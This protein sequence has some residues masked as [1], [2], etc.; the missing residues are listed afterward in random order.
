MVTNL[1]TMKA[2]TFGGWVASSFRR[3]CSKWSYWTSMI[4]FLISGLKK[5]FKE[6]L[7]IRFLREKLRGHFVTLQKSLFFCSI[8]HPTQVM[9]G[10]GGRKLIRV[11]D[12]TSDI[13]Y[14]HSWRRCGGHGRSEK[15]RRFGVLNWKENWWIKGSLFQSA[16]SLMRLRY[17]HA[18]KPILWKAWVLTRLE[19][20]EFCPELME[21][22]SRIPPNQWV[23]VDLH[24]RFLETSTPCSYLSRLDVPN[25]DGS[26][27]YC[28][29]LNGWNQ[30][31]V[32]DQ[33][34]F[35]WRGNQ[36]CCWIWTTYYRHNTKKSRKKAAGFQNLAVRSG[37]T[38]LVQIPWF[39]WQ[40]HLWRPGFLQCQDVPGRDGKMLLVLLARR[41]AGRWC[42]GCF[43]F[44]R[45]KV[46]KLAVGETM[47][48]LLS[49]FIWGK[50]RYL[51]SVCVSCIFQSTTLWKHG[52]FFHS[53]G[54]SLPKKLEVSIWFA[55][56]E[57]MENLHPKYVTLTTFDV[58]VFAWIFRS[59]RCIEKS[60][61][62]AVVMLALAGVL[63]KE[64]WFS[65]IFIIVEPMWTMSVLSGSSWSMNP[66]A[67]RCP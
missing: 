31:K 2:K 4:L 5:D 52:L 58:R 45:T 21:L 32:K 9:Q 3:V 29:D 27:V 61:K 67:C 14:F 48:F 25:W 40:T 22:D 17:F 20:M 34:S 56:Q 1:Q 11:K 6:R 64:S 28:Y 15:L 46:V 53:H 42:L 23:V 55:I 62:G 30:P 36:I 19:M 38:L 60:W 13:L 12:G 44:F 7:Y 49:P 18:L 8:F 35:V 54:V 50:I 24:R 33:H 10:R 47:M 39:T 37:P 41:T 57:A 59:S 43:S 65:M 26:L 16:K 51:W 66:L 63:S